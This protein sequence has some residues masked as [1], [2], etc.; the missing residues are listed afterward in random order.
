MIHK[1]LK[2]RDSIPYSPEIPSNNSPKN[3][4]DSH[5]YISPLNDGMWDLNT[6]AEMN[7]F[8]IGNIQTS[9]RELRS[10]INKLDTKAIIQGI[11]LDQ[12]EN[13]V[14]TQKYKS[15]DKSVS[16]APLFWKLEYQNENSLNRI[17]TLE[18]K[19]K[20][21]KDEVSNMTD[22]NEADDGVV[23]DRIDDMV[24]TG[25]KISDGNYE[26]VKNDIPVL[27]QSIKLLLNSLNLKNVDEED[28]GLLKELAN[29]PKRQVKQLL[30]ANFTRIQNIF[31]TLKPELDKVY[32]S[33]EDVASDSEES[34]DEEKEGSEP[35]DESQSDNEEQQS[36][37]DGTQ[38]E[39]EEPQNE[40]E[41]THSEDEEPQ[42]KDDESSSENEEPNSEV[43]EPQ[44][45]DSAD[46][47]SE[48]FIHN[49]DTVENQT[50]ASETDSNTNDSVYMR[51]WGI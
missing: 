29:S 12:V 14:K 23:I 7:K 39:N 40:D 36:E 50:N 31:K 15:S 46:N 2:Y 10:L 11:V 19:V 49:S 9:I 33:T 44:H 18:N 32:E 42:R 43:D 45:Q 37:D 48:I 3:G 21:L 30:R 22:S 38:S 24:E 20:E 47:T 8:D 13:Y 17:H 27:R 28:I 4:L 26:E 25:G 6:T 35:E 16:T 1:H 51:T 5:S 34:E 41:E